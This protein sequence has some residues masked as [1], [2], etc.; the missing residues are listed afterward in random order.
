MRYV[1]LAVA[2]AMSVATG[3]ARAAA[4]SDRQHVPRMEFVA[5][6][7][8]SYE[9]ERIQPVADGSLLNSAGE[10]QHLSGFTHGKITLLTFFYTYCVDPWGCPF[11]Y[12]TL[13]GLRERVLA[14]PGLAQ[15]VRFVNISFDPANDTPQAIARYGAAFERDSRFEW[16][17]LT[18]R[19]VADLLPVLDGFGQDVAVVRDA[20]GRPTR[21]INHMLK[22]FLIDREGFVRE[23][24][25]LAYLHQQVMLNDIK[26][27]ALEERIAPAR[28]TEP[29]AVAGESAAQR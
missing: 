22:L 8:G 15:R 29:A 25:S 14:E 11:A 4:D 17:F 3:A 12:Q 28:R 26:T 6:A 24:Y 2:V 10:L 7:A 5:P 16:R 23:I 20:A 27:L 1:V 18:A 13:T 19:T 9:L 21:T